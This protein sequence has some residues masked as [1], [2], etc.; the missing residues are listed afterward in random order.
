LHL[1]TFSRDKN[2]LKTLDKESD[3]AGV[4]KFTNFIDTN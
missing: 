4:A 1:S 2:F 3:P